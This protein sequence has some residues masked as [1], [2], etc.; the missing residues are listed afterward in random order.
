[1]PH[2]A[3]TVGV[4]PALVLLALVAAGCGPTGP[5][6]R[7]APDATAAG[8]PDHSVDQVIGAVAASVAPVQ[9]AA[10]DGDLV[11]DGPDGSQSASFSFR[12][13]LADSVAVVVRGPL[14]VVAGRGLA[15]PDSF[16]AADRINRQL[17]YGPAAAAERYVPGAGSSERLAQAALGLLVPDAGVAWSL[18]AQDGL[19]RLV[20]RL[21]S[22]AAREITVDPALWRVVRVREFDGAGRSVG[23][24]EAEAFD[25]V[26]GVVLPRRVRLRGGGTTVTLEHRRLAVNPPDLRLRFERPA[27][28]E[29]F[30][31]Q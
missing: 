27:D 4:R 31:I 13:R 26:D 12:A 21:P 8:Y 11:V 5:L 7:D 9:S 22:G 10:A 17:F 3:P 14:G 16:Y 23:G 6:V 19:Y 29:A 28:Y 30:P 2:V 24:V 18:T 20:G 1:M 15:T 25:T